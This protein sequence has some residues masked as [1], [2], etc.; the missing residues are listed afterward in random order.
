MPGRRSSAWPD[1]SAPDELE[2]ARCA[3]D[4]VVAGRPG[5]RRRLRVRRARRGR[6]ARRLACRLRPGVDL[7]IVGFDDSELA[8][9][10][11]LTSVAQPMDEVAYDRP[12]LVGE[13][14]SGADAGRTAASCSSPT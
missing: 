12:R 4:V 2:A 14:L 13:S 8:R 9:M 10:H 1:G 7:G 3:A 5:R 11:G 6:P